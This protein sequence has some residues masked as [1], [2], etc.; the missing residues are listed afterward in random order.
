M[1]ARQYL[2]SPANHT[3]REKKRLLHCA[4]YK[5]KNIRFLNGEIISADKIRNANTQR[6]KSGYRFQLGFG[7]D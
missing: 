7:Y 3:L 2:W 6:K 4:H 5:C 1:I